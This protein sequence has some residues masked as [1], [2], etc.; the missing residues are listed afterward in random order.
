[1]TPVV[2]EEFG[3]SLAA[4]VRRRFGVRE[5]TTWIVIAAATAVLVV[6]AL[7]AASVLNHDEQVTRTDQPQ[8]TVIYPSKLMHPAKPEPGELQRFEGRR[9]RT[10]AVVSVRPLR[11]QPYDG[12]ASKAILPVYSET[13]RKGLEAATPGFRLTEEGKAN[14]QGAP[15]WQMQYR[16]GDERNSTVAQDVLLL[17][18]D[19]GSEGGVILSFRLTKHYRKRLK[20]RDEELRKAA[21]STFRSFRFGT[22]RP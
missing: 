20:P 12:D 2:R 17:P 15:G 13:F 8:F 5:R 11:L 22:T 9:G 1:M 6:G 7:V 18:D 10:L 19:Q 4:L 21:R 14:V 16:S 3:P